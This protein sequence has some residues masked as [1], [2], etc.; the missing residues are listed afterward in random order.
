[1]K[2]NKEGKLLALRL[3][4]SA[5]SDENSVDIVEESETFR[6]P[7]SATA[8][9]S[10]SSST[11]VSSSSSSSSNSSSSS[12]TREFE[13]IDSVKRRLIDQAASSSARII[14]ELQEA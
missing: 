10:S 2:M 11:I 8:S 7:A 6:F 14:E 1:M 12:L 9:L 4:S 5:S 13:N 3:V